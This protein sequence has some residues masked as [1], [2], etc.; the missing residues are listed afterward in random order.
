[1]GETSNQIE[2][3]I[4]ETRNDLSENFSELE[5]RVK[6]AI[7]WR[8]QFEDRP[9][10]MMALAF[11]G[12]V[13]FSAL[14]PSLGPRRRRSSTARRNAPRDGSDLFF[15][16]RTAYDDKTNQPLEAWDAVK[17]ALVGVATSKLSHVIEELLPGSKQEFAKAV[18]PER[19]NAGQPRC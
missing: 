4:Q 9:M 15:K 8:A 13:L 16:S 12:G 5:V 2:R 11:G 3:H 18:K 1:M 17:G 14:L 7:D 19:N 10:T 6:T